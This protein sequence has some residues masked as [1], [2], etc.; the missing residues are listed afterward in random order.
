VDL[1]VVKGIPYN[2][3]EETFFSVLFEDVVVNSTIELIHHETFVAGT[4][5]DG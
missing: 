3:R 2:V 5:Y 4:G 1:G